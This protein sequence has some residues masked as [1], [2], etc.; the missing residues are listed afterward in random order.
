MKLCALSRGARLAVVLMLVLS[1]AYAATGKATTARAASPQTASSFS[2][3]IVPNYSA[4]PDAVFYN[5]NYYLLY[6]QGLDNAITVRRATSL[7]L[8]NSSPNITVYTADSQTNGFIGYGGFFFHYSSHWYIYDNEFAASPYRAFV[9]QSSGDDPIGPYTFLADLAG[10]GPGNNSYVNSAVLVN[11][12][13][14][15]IQTADSPNGHGLYIATMSNPWTVSSGFTLISNPT[16][17]WENGIDEGGSFRIRGNTIYD[18]FSAGVFQDPSYCV[19]LLTASTGANLLQA[20]SWTKSSGCV[21]S[22]NPSG[23]VYGPG[24]MTWFSSPDGT[25]DWVA[26][27]GKTNSGS[28]SG[29]TDRRINA[30]QVTWDGSGNPVFGSPLALS[31]YAGLPSGD[32]GYPV[33]EAESAIITDAQ[34]R[35]SGS[36]S[37]AA[38]VGGI[39]NADSSVSLQVS[40]TSAG[41]YS[42]RVYFANGWTAAAA[43]NLTVNG[44]S[45]QTV[46]YPITGSWGTFPNANFVTVTVSLTS[47]NNS[48][49]FQHASNYAELDKIEPV[50]GGGTGGTGALTQV[51]G[52]ANNISVGADG[53]VIAVAPDN[54]VWRYTGSG[55]LPWTEITGGLLTRVA[56]RSANDLWGRATNGTIWRYN[57][58]S[59]SNIAGNGTDIAAG[60]DGSVWRTDPIGTYAWTG[61]TSTTDPNVNWTL[62]SGSSP[63][64]AALV[65]QVSGKSPTDIWGVDSSTRIWHYNGTAWKQV[66]GGLI[67]VSEGADGTVEGTAPDDRVWLY[68]GSGSLPWTERPGPL[69]QL[70]VGTISNLWGVDSS[71][72]IFRTL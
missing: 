52:G 65:N 26:Y 36:A 4:D 70:S 24:S 25:Q 6:N 39:D 71:T 69:A 12:Q 1:I 22:S 29:G 30:K 19:G 53:T 9:L 16:N 72:N 3:P 15:S 63:S 58:S 57:G 51:A 45:P 10:P 47:G 44:S 21:F 46:T 48:M 2:G 8:L 55:S 64:G 18:I 66:A 60:A 37:G 33:W 61:G 32:T 13:L 17:G 50:V 49:T 41:S 59:W 11:S 20:S 23:G 5:G 54:R 38:Y 68:T 42:F 62:V 35:S 34:V 43:H 40:E 28:V 67:W 31:T 7:G 56:V 14:Y 27:H